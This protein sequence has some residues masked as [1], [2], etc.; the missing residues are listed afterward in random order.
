MII[1]DENI[2]QILV[3]KLKD[4]TDDVISIREEYPGIIDEEVIALAKSDKGLV[5][6]EDKDFG[7]L[8][9]SYNFRG[10]SVMLLRYGKSDFDA[11]EQNVFKALDYYKNKPGHYFLTV[12]DKKI[13]VRKI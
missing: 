1:I 9:F 12:T 8:I 2:E 10:C 6:T 7:E 4:Y 3:R 11:I 5:I 13:R